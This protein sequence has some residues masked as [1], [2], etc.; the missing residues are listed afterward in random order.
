MLH[1]TGDQS[2]ECRAHGNLGS[3][4]FSKGSY[5]EALANHRNQ[6]VLA[7]KL[8]EREV[9]FKRETKFLT[10]KIYQR[11]LIHV[12]ALV[13][14]WSQF[15]T[16]TELENSGSDTH[17]KQLDFHTLHMWGCDPVA[18]LG[19]NLYYKCWFCFG[20]PLYKYNRVGLNEMW[21]IKVWHWLYHGFLNSDLLS[22]CGHSGG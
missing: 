16:L 6:L 13:W 12:N 2:G 17:I 3:A 15:E 4:L 21:E 5:R 1:P 7:M 19:P 11:T 14:P 20:F 8:K 18:D 9:C 10:T 22:C